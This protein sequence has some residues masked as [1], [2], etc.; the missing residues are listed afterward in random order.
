[1]Y[2]FHAVL[3]A[4]CSFFTNRPINVDRFYT[5]TRR[6]LIAASNSQLAVHSLDKNYFKYVS[7]RIEKDKC[8]PEASHEMTVFGEEPR[9]ATAAVIFHDCITSRFMNK[10]DLEQELIKKLY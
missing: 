10:I 8:F 1:M 7:T 6:K 2:K 9:A 3:L 4:H 5:S